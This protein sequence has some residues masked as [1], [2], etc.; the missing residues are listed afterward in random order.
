MR[1]FILSL[2]VAALV[3]GALTSCGNGSTAS[4]EDQAFGDTLAT[5]LGQY[6][7]VSQ[8]EMLARMKA[9]MSPEEF[10]K[11][12]KADFLAGLKSV[13][14]ADT[15]KMAYFQGVQL[16]LQLLQPITGVSQN[17]GIP[18]NPKLVYEAFK[19]VYEKDSITDAE[20]Y[21]NAYQEVFQ[22]FQ[23]RARV[24]EEKRISESEE[25]QTNLKAGAEYAAKAVKEGYTKA[26][27][28]I[29]Y[30]IEEPGTGDKVK[31]TDKV[32]INYKGKKI[33]GSVFDENQGKPYTASASAFIPGFNEALT[34]LAKGG[35]M[36]VII[37]GELAYGLQGAGSMIGP[38]ETLVFDIE[39]LDVEAPAAAATP[40]TAATR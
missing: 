13:L 21:K 20:S 23:E 4:K 8:Q 1:K 37:P 26:A 14:E 3:G 30:K 31:P 17:Y 15:S 27:S 34:M 11:F 9:N 39:I 18:V 33:D 29:V 7:G 40:E 32:T 35:K 36:T 2:G 16:G 24:A 22:R 6:A 38:N 19:E 5:N 12:S 10:A 25:N 28:G